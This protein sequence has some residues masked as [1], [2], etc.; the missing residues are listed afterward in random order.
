MNIDE[1]RKAF[2][3]WV[4]TFCDYEDLSVYELDVMQA[5][6]IASA[7]RDGYKLVPVE[8]TQVNVRCGLMMRQ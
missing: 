2:E 4:K 7:N 8:P 1:Q 5:A 3:D 6:W